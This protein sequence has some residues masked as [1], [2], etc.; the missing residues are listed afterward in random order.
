MT[1][2]TSVT[3]LLSFVTA[4]VAARRPVDGRESRSRHRFLVAVGRLP[5]PFDRFAD[6]THI[7]GSAV[8]IGPEGVLLHLHKKLRIW[9]QPGGHLDPGETPWDAALREATEETGL[10]FSAW[11]AT[12]PLLHLDVHPG[13]SG[14][15]HL[16]LRYLLHA[17]GSPRPAA[18]ESPSVQWFDWPEAIEVA[19]PGLSG[20]LRSMQHH[21]PSVTS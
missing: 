8:V 5:N 16:D 11:S 20:L 17:S 9:L 6:P 10:S 19:D 12:P 4:S 21:T 3:D 15:T 7:T 2:A 13:G 1:T 14:H 18:G